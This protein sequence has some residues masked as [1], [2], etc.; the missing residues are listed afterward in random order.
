MAGAIDGLPSD[1]LRGPSLIYRSMPGWSLA[2]G[3]VNS[4]GA[5]GEKPSRQCLVPSLI[6]SSA[7]FCGE[8]LRVC[9]RPCVCVFTDG[10]FGRCH[11]VPVKEAY[12]Y[13]V[14]PPVVQRFRMLLE[15][16]SNRGEQTM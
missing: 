15:K 1:R 10:M 6:L 16:L 3:G 8:R 2:P 4:P 9:V 13:D 14:S 12:T 7:H 5:A 11:S